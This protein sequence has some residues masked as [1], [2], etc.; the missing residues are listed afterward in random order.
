M[1][2][3]A[4]NLYEELDFSMCLRSNIACFSTLWETYGAINFLDAFTFER[5]NYVTK[6]CINMRSMQPGNKPKDSVRVNN[7]TGANDKRR[8]IMVEEYGM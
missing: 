2:I 5:S 1:K 8:K 7:S 3:L 4:K 6:N